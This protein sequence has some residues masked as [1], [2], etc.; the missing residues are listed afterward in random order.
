MT[1]QELE[2]RLKE[3]ERM[4]FFHAMKDRWDA[5]DFEYARKISREIRELKEQLEK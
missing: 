5:S 1:R 4:E 3:A 2:K